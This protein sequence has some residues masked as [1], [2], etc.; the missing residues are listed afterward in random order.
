[1]R[2]AGNIL[3]ATGAALFASFVLGLLTGHSY[4]KKGQGGTGLSLH[5]RGEEPS[6]AFA[7]R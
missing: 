2:V 5:D 6:A 4:S 1:M 7:G 3:F